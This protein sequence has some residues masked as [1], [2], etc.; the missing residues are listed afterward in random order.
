MP[1]QNPPENSKFQQ[2][3]RFLLDYFL[4]SDTK[5][6]GRFL[7]AGSLLCTLTVSGLGLIFGWWC[8]PFL[9]NAFIAKDLTL[10]LMGVAAGTS[11]ASTMAAFNWLSTRLKNSLYVDWR[12]WL[13]KKI[14]DQY[15]NKKKYLDISRC[16][17]ELDNPDQ[18]IEESVGKVVGSFLDLSLGLIDNVINL[19]SYMVLLGTT[20]GMLSFV[21]LNVT[22]IIPG[23]LIYVSLL[24]GGATSLIGYYI[25]KSLQKNM[26]EEIELK[27][28]F[29]LDLR[30]VIDSAEEIAIEHGE[31]YY[32][33]RLTNNFA[34]LNAK[35]EQRL[36]V[37]NEIASFNLFNGIF[38][39]I[40]PIVVAAPLYF[41]NL[42]TLDAF[43][44]SSYYFSVVT[45]CLNWF[46]NSYEIIN[47][48]NTSLDRMMELQTLLDEPTTNSTLSVLNQLGVQRYVNDSSNNLQINNLNLSMHNDSNQLII[49]GLNLSFEP[50]VHTLIQGPS[51]MGKSSIFKAIAGSW[52]SGEGEI[53]IPNSLES[54]YF[55]PQKPSLP[56]D[57]LR[58]VL[59]Y[60]D[61]K[62]SYS[63]AELISALRAVDMESIIGKLNEKVG[64]KSLGEQQ[65]IAFARVLL[66]KPTWV[67]LDEATASL[68]EEKEALVYQKIK[69]LLPNTTIIS[70][71]H[72]STVKPY[73]DNILFF[74]IDNRREVTVRVED[75]ASFSLCSNG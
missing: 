68:D 37:E 75:N 27:S 61:E 1:N 71:A 28:N 21:F 32:Q 51:G 16:Y 34:K 74:G 18:R 55:L 66:R 72:R 54:I 7:F 41:N 49:K 8:F 46:I 12:T 53:R 45:R 22:W 62:C 13:T 40:V 4:H 11:I 36:E 5:W 58:N 20:G 64:Y 38:Q 59:A 9:Y 30:H 19:V 6:T 15:I 67:F 17:P 50:G 42:L 23:Y 65:R 73:H 47:Q 14:L 31:D 29:R 2:S 39:A 48:F 57:T 10:F 70:I 52:L 24:V 33:T 44:A 63:E 35:S 26:K 3:Q 69:E 60:P 56:D 25:N 43:W